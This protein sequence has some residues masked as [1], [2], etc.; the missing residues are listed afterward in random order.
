MYYT[1]THTTCMAPLN[2]DTG[3]FYLLYN[4]KTWMEPLV[5]IS[6]AHHPTTHNS[7]ALFFFG[8]WAWMGK[9]CKLYILDVCR[10]VYVYTSILH[11]LQLSCHPVVLFWSE[12]VLP[13][14]VYW[15]GWVAKSW[16]WLVKEVG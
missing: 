6:H 4:H 3:W 9:Q 13:E 5:Q 11:A 14:H 1:H 2:S 7:H 8:E 10:Y 16:E 15:S 12:T